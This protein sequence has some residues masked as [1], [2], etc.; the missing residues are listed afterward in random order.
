MA[1]V[2]SDFNH[3]V[4]S[5]PRNFFRLF[6]M[7]WLLDKKF[8]EKAALDAGSG[9]GTLAIKLAKKGYAVWAVDSDRQSCEILV[10]RMSAVG[11]KVGI[12]VSCASL[13]DVKLP[14][15]HFDVITCGEVLEHIDRDSELLKKFYGLLKQGGILILSVPLEAKGWDTW[16]DMTGHKR[17]YSY[18][19]LSHFLESLGFTVEKSFFWGRPFARLYSRYIFLKWA[20][21]S[22]TEQEIRKEKLV[23]TRIGKSRI[24]SLCVGCLFFLDLFFT[25]PQKA[26]GTIVKA[27]KNA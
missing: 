1:L 19:S 25:S 3:G 10:K 17:L 11:L 15:G 5:G 26:I 4:R 23:C 14:Q 24:I 7:E 8:G 9:D 2:I 21:K 20:N 18:G 13:L 12:T 27:R 16:D 6:L 22:E